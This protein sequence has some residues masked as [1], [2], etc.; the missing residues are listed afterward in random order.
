MAMRSNVG[1]KTTPSRPPQSGT[2]HWNCM[3]VR[4][5]QPCGDSSLFTAQTEHIELHNHLAAVTASRQEA[6]AETQRMQHETQHIQ[7]QT[8]WIRMMFW[9]LRFQPYA[10][11]ASYTQL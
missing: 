1:M 5:Q 4:S 10:G 9:K 11:I 3:S 2:L 6:H 8:H 7:V